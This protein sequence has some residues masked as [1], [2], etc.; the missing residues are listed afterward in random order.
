MVTKQYIVTS[1]NSPLTIPVNPRGGPLGV[2]ATPTAATYTVEMSLTPINEG[3]TNNLFDVT[4]MVSATTK[5]QVQIGPIESLLVTLDSGTSVTID[6][7][8]SDV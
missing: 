7:T 8:Q 3:L 2:G 6:V 4:G 1:G 5:Q